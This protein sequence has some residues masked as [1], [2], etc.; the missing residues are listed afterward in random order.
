MTVVY[1]DILLALNLFID[2]L[3]LCATA[4]V[5]HLPVT[6]TRLILGALV[7]A[8]SSLVI[9]LPPLGAV[10]SILYKLGGALLMVPVAFRIRSFASFCK[11]VLALFVISALFAGICNGLYLLTAPRGVVVQ[12]G[13]V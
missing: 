9:L 7:G 2:Y 10:M 1:I 12:S 11:A 3:L 5:L 13:V 6:R 8:V 4:R